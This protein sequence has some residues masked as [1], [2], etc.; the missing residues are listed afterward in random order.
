M[1]TSPDLPCGD[2]WKLMTVSPSSGGQGH[3]WSKWNRWGDHHTGWEYLLLQIKFKCLHYLL[4]NL[5]FQQQNSEW[6]LPP[7][8]TVACSLVGLDGLSERCAQYKK[9]G[10]DF[11]KWRCVLKISDGCPSALAIAENAN[12]LARYASIC[13]QVM[14]H[15]NWIRPVQNV[16]SEF[17]I[18]NVCMYVARMA[19]SLLWSQRSFLTET[20]TWSVA[21]TSQKRLVHQQ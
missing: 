19:W 14:L 17:L 20:T 3:S 18:L 4:A 1:E 16:G 21:S 7:R 6:A 2:S 12:V 5:N 11:A 13:Q 8:H 9:D 15:G 10:C